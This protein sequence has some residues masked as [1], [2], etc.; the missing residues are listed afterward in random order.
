MHLLTSVNTFSFL[1]DSTIVNT[2]NVFKVEKCECKNKSLRIVGPER[3]IF[4][5]IKVR[6]LEILRLLARLFFSSRRRRALS[7]SLCL[8]KWCG[9]K[10]FIRFNRTCQSC[11]RKHIFFFYISCAVADCAPTFFLLLYVPGQ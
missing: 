6:C 4:T 10:F 7:L 3:I 5:S 1:N 2:K 11:H 9:E 8:H